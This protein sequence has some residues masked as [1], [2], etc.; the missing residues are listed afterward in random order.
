MTNKYFNAVKGALA[1]EFKG[2]NEPVGVN[3][4]DM[5]AILAVAGA[6]T[7]GAYYLATNKDSII[8]GVQETFSMDAQQGAKTFSAHTLT[9]G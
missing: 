9:L 5:I 2:A 7:A 3:V 8:D 1:Y 6:I 4:G